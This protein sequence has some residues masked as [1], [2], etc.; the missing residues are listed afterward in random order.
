MQETVQEQIIK[1]GLKNLFIKNTKS[2]PLPFREPDKIDPGS[3]R[4]A[5]LSQ[6]H[7]WPPAPP[8]KRAL[9]EVVEA[10]QAE[11]ILVEEWKEV[12]DI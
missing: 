4:I 12:P 2:P 7:D 3:L 11:G 8:V 5:F 1:V 10:L 6:I 9:L